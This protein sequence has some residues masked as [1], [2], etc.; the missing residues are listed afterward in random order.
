[1]RV[2]LVEDDP[3]LAAVLER[4]FRRDGL[5]CDVASSRQQAEEL[6]YLHQY[7]LL[8][9]DRRLPDG[10]GLQLC[11]ELRAQGFATS[12]LVLTA[13]AEV[14]Q[15]V[16]GLSAG[17]DD[18]LGKPFDLEVLRAKVKALLRRNLLRPAQVLSFGDLQL[19]PFRRT[20]ACH[21]QPLPLTAREL[22]ILEGLFRNPGG[23]V[24][25][26]DLFEQAWGEREQPMS[27]TIEVLVS[28]LRR[29]LREAGSAVTI[30]AVKGLG[31]RLR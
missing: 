29:K 31:Y 18:Y 25:R 13:L 20:V 23:I 27:N 22:A 12:V 5:T 2:L 21:G 10:D 14:P 6:L 19:D 4:T 30:E 17:A 9:L 11:A 26:E 7:D 24:S 3:R 28:R 15:V 16:E 8:I 1:M